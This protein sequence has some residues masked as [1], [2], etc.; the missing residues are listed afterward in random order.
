MRDVFAIAG[1]LSVSTGAGLAYVPAGL[2]VFGAFLL[3][4]GLVGHFRGVVNGP[5]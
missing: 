4:G 3:L 5:T 1:V 2:I